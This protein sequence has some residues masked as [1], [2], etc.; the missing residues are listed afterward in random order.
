MREV[1]RRRGVLWRVGRGRRLEA[2]RRRGQQLA[3]VRCVDER[4]VRRLATHTL[5]RAVA[6]L[7]ALVRSQREHR[8]RLLAWHQRLRALDSAPARTHRGCT[9]R[10]SSRAESRI[11]TGH[12]WKRTGVRVERRTGLASASNSHTCTRASD[13]A[14]GSSSS[15]ASSLVRKANPRGRRC[16]G[17]RGRRGLRRAL[18]CLGWSCWSLSCW[19]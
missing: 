1:A 10:R 15:S 19:G 17:R 18:G 14:D 5:Q 3:P 6:L 4:V 8:V 9:R 11:E 2:L 16:R 7:E 12:R 13:G